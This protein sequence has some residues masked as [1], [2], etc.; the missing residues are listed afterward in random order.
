MI[1]TTNPDTFD[2]LL[3]VS[4]IIYIGK[5]SGG[6]ATILQSSNCKLSSVSSCMDTGYIW[7][8]GAVSRHTAA[9]D[10]G[11]CS[12]YNFYLLL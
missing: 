5:D 8:Y 4:S 6:R 12:V 9:V 11:V 1:F 7:E 2:K 10:I 3:S